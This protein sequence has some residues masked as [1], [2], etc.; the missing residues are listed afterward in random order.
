MFTYSRIGSGYAHVGGLTCVFTGIKPVCGDEHV[1]TYASMPMS[2]RRGV[3]HD[4]V[5]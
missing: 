2:R 1:K 4:N 5:T 3:A